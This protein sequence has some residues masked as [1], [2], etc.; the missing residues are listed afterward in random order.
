MFFVRFKSLRLQLNIYTWFDA[1]LNRESVVLTKQSID[2][3][4]D[5]NFIFFL[6]ML[7]FTN[8]DNNILSNENVFTW[9]DLTSFSTDVKK[10]VWYS[11]K[12]TI[13]SSYRFMQNNFPLTTLNLLLHL[14][15]IH[16]ISPKQVLIKY[17]KSVCSL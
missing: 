13:P 1:R 16:I 4:R 12:Q 14:M 9:Q 7:V 10:N 5:L 6:K 2:G 8:D 3:N 17:N 11:Y 15:D